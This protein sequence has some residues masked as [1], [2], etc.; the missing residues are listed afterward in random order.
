MSALERERER[1]YID[2]SVQLVT[3]ACH[4]KYYFGYVLLQ[5]LKA[6]LMSSFSVPRSHGFLLREKVIT[7]SN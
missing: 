5:E 3:D 7:I 6:V 2:F 1:G 4:V